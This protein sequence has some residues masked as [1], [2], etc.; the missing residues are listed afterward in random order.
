MSLYIGKDAS[1][2]NILH[3]TSNAVEIGAISEGSLLNTT[4][5]N[6]KY[7]ITTILHSTT[8]NIPGFISPYQIAYVELPSSISSYLQSSQNYVFILIQGDDGIY[9]DCGTSGIFI[10][11]VGS[12]YYL[13]NTNNSLAGNNSL[14]VVTN[15]Y[16]YPVGSVYIS[17]QKIEIGSIDITNKKLLTIHKAGNSLYKVSYPL[18]DNNILSLV[19]MDTAV[20]VGLDNKS[21]VY[22]DSIGNM[23]EVL[24]ETASNR[25][26]SLHNG[27]VLGYVESAS[28]TP[29]D[30]EAIVATLPSSIV[31]SGVRFLNITIPMSFYYAESFS[32]SGNNWT[33]LLRL[34]T[35]TNKSFIIDALFFPF[36]RCRFEYNSSNRIVKARL[37]RETDQV[38]S[39]YTGV[40]NP[41]INYYTL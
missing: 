7:P 41:T 3:I 37:Y 26:S 31:S 5:F 2:Q 20:S 22:Y 9:R 4:I 11:L 6:N 36:L 17:N 12:S 14:V 34:S 13:A 27:S 10:S 23:Y 28:A 16:T 39:Y 40:S 29:Y 8:V 15:T 25:I 30:G 32:G 35:Y 18:E 1:S 19:N 38:E 24:S 21:I 33:G